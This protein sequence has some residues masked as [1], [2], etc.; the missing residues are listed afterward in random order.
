MDLQD[1]PVDI[2]TFYSGTTLM[3]GPFTSSG[4][5]QKPYYP[6]LAFRRL[7]DSPHRVTV[8]GPSD[9]AVT[10]LAGLSNDR[11]TLRVLISNLSSEKHSVRIELH[12]LPWKGPVEYQKQVVSNRYDLETVPSAKAIASSLTE[13]L[14]RQSLSLLTF[15]FRS[16]GNI[17]NQ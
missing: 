10:A 3:W 1:A 4:A 2:A 9:S 8:D 16:A 11:E 7:L 6:F 14:D 12:G 5:P 13:T 15:R 17:T